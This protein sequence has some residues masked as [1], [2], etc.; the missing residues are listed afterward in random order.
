MTTR[1]LPSPSAP[2]ALADDIGVSDRFWQAQADYAPTNYHYNSL[3]AITADAHLIV[4]GRLIGTRRGELQPF[5]APEGMADGR[6]VIFGVVAVDEVLKGSPNMLLP[7]EVLVARVGA[8]N[9]NPD[10]LPRG[11]VV[12]FLMNYQLLRKELGVG[13]SSDLNDRFYYV[14]PN[15]YQCVLRNLDGVVRIVRPAED[16]GEVLQGFPLV[17]DGES[18]PAVLDSIRQSVADE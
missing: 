10:E 4:R 16:S 9:Q 7:G 5:Q 6:A 17:L 12:L 13:P 2:A 1:V 3:A 14:R 15:G 8:E 11:E 18:F